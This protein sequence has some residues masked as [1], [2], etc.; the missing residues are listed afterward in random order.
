[1]TPNTAIDADSLRSRVMAGAVEQKITE[2]IV[3]QSKQT[4]E[5]QFLETKESSIVY[6]GKNIYRIDRLPVKPKDKIKIV[7]E[8]TNSEW[9]QG[10]RINIDIEMVVNGVKAKKFI[11]WE[12]S[13]P[14]EVIVECT[15]TKDCE[16]RIYNAWDSGKGSTDAWIGNSG[17]FIEELQNG[18]RYRCND[19]F[20]DDDFDDLVFRVERII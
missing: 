2:G 6:K 18:R 7:W 17:F 4:I 5:Q 15:K 9:K 8:S 1:M 13:S 19:G 11:L 3:T 12:D 14:R 20:P 10:I 16:I